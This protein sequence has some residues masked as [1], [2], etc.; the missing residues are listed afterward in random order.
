MLCLI[1]PVTVSET[2]HLD[3]DTYLELGHVLV[4]IEGRREGVV[5]RA[6]AKRCWR[7][8]ASAPSRARSPIERGTLWAAR[9]GA[10]ARARGS[11]DRRTLAAKARRRPCPALVS[12]AV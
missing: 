2:R 12:R 1:E 5:D 7:P 4:S 8:T 11:V 3:L 9:D 10:A 6:L